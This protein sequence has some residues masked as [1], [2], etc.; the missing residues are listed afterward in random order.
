[1][2]GG[3]IVSSADLMPAGR[4]SAT[5]PE[6]ANPVLIEPNDLLGPSHGE[7]PQPQ[8]KPRAELAGPSLLIVEEQDP[9]E[10]HDTVIAETTTLLDIDS[11]S[12]EGSVPKLIGEGPESVAQLEQALGPYNVR[13]YQEFRARHIESAVGVIDNFLNEPPA[14]LS[15]KQ[16]DELIA[17]KEELNSLAGDKKQPFDLSKADDPKHPPT[18]LLENM[19]EKLVGGTAGLERGWF[20]CMFS[21][22]ARRARAIQKRAEQGKSFSD[23]YSGKKLA[24]IHPKAALALYMRGR[25]KRIGLGDLTR[26]A[27]VQLSKQLATGYLERTQRSQ[28]WST[29]SR[30]HKFPLSGSPDS[31]IIAMQSTLTPASELQ[32]LS[33]TFVNG[34]LGISSMNSKETQHAV[35]L[36]KTEF[37]TVEPS[38]GISFKG[39]R[40]GVL[41]AY[42]IKEESARDE[43]NL[44]KAS[45]LV[46]A[47]ASEMRSAITKSDSGQWT[48]PMVSVSL[49]TGGFSPTPKTYF[50]ADTEMISA[51]EKALQSLAEGDGIDMPG[52]DPNGK[53]GP[54]KLKPVVNQFFIGVNDLALGIFTNHWSKYE[55]KNNAAIAALLEQADTQLDRLKT[56][57]RSSASAG[58]MT[59][60]ALSNRISVIEELTEQIRGLQADGQYKKVNNDPYKFPPR[61][62]LLAHLLGNAACFNCKSGKDRT[63]MVDIEIKALLQSINRNIVQRESGGKGR[64]VPQY[65]A[66]RDD[67][68]KAAFAELHQWGGGQQVS[69][70]NTGLMGNKSDIGTYLRD[71]LDAATVELVHGFARHADGNK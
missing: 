5:Q 20:R 36:W 3:S 8:A 39:F 55:D 40:H 56:Q 69:R 68:A 17:L 28:A 9:R 13:D 45:E 19:R 48:I 61:I 11:R 42:G 66:R 65:G 58:E 24:R 70:A 46:R 6:Q 57:Y 30:V 67:Q 53:E 10:T 7:H 71:N 2:A 23:I 35:N 54:W 50:R 43:A 14:N 52:P 4:T 16:R 31:K 1:M 34:V 60:A 64:L 47:A 51:Q 25:F 63:G 21:R 18:S 41:D 49:Q 37:T 32:G 22:N 29:Y 44:N 59:N 33:N 62:L 15:D 38:D 12:N 27:T 26:A